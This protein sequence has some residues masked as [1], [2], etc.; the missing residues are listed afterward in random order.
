MQ[1]KAEVTRIP[2]CVRDL[3]DIYFLFLLLFF[4]YCRSL[5]FR[6][7]AWY[8]TICQCSIKQQRYVDMAD[9]FHPSSEEV[10]VSRKT[11]K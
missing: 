11:V 8:S 3:A 1:F 7:I 4:F 6:A 9:G 5:I 10:H 2:H